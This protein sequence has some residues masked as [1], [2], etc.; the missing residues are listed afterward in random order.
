[1]KEKIEGWD[2]WSAWGLGLCQ[3]LPIS[4]DPALC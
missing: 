2:S 4:A 3:A 1:M